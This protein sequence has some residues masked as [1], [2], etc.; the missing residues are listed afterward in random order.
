MKSAQERRA[1]LEIKMGEQE[2]TG[3]QQQKSRIN[4]GLK[5]LMPVTGPEDLLKSQ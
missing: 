1:R 5:K 4:S 3:G 2:Q